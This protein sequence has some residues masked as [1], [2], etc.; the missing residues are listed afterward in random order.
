MALICARIGTRAGE[1]GLTR[2]RLA[3]QLAPGSL[4]L[5]GCQAGHVVVA[6][7]QPGAVFLLGDHCL[8]LAAQVSLD[9]GIGRDPRDGALQLAA[10]VAQLIRGQRV[11]RMLGRLDGHV[12]GG[13]RRVAQGRLCGAG[14]GATSRGTGRAQ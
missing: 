10:V 1:S 4:E 9:R 14:H 12:P 5:A 2:A 3:V 8:E 11:H 7:G 13:R 6:P